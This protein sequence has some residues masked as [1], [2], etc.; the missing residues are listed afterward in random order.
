VLRVRLL[1]GVFPRRGI[2]GSALGFRSGASVIEWLV[3]TQPVD[4]I[5]SDN[6]R[7]LFDLVAFKPNEL[8]ERRVKGSNAEHKK[9]HDS[10]WNAKLRPVTLKMTWKNCGTGWKIYTDRSQVKLEMELLEEDEANA[11]KYH[12]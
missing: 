3:F 7:M 5:L 11:D 8:K 9:W 2:P 6:P 4:T 1:L 12:D 10:L